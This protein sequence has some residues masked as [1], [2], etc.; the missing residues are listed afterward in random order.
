MRNKNK[1]QTPS[2]GAKLPEPPKV[3]LES[4]VI[5]LERSIESY[6]RGVFIKDEVKS[7][8]GSNHPANMV[9]E[10]VVTHLG[11]RYRR[12]TVGRILVP[13]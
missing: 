3:S 8:V 11:M 12:G 13:E 9:L 5:A 2:I 6:R 4:R 1:N 10:A 7:S